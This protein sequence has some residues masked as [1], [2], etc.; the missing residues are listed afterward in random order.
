M[1]AAAGAAARN[2]DHTV[3]VVI[4]VYRGAETLPPVVGVARSA[5]AKPLFLVVND[6]AAGPLGRAAAL[7]APPEVERPE[8]KPTPAAA[9]PVHAEW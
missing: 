2:S 3:A 9:P 6:R 5:M 7:P 8:R 1:T 4:P